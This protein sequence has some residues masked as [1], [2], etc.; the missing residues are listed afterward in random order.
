MILTN[1]GVGLTLSGPLL[2]CASWG[3]A[4]SHMHNGDS[5]SSISVVSKI[6][7]SRN[8]SGN[9]KKGL[10]HNKENTFSHPQMSCQ[11]HLAG[12]GLA[13]FFCLLTLPSPRSLPSCQEGEK[14]IPVHEEWQNYH[15]LF[16]RPFPP[17]NVQHSISPKKDRSLLGVSLVPDVKITI[18]FTSLLLNAHQNYNTVITLW[19]Y[20][21]LPFL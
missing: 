11:L 18:T 10:H 15:V 17:T 4:P 16:C 8:V 12:S 13:P 14:P 6:N 21:L 19:I 20:L 7:L 5:A 3:P 9:P 1:P 2:S